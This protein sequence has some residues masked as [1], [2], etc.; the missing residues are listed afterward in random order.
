MF[1]FLLKIFFWFYPLISLLIIIG[2]YNFNYEK[3]KVINKAKRI[4]IND[5]IILGDS[6]IGQLNRNGFYNA[7]I[8]GENYSIILKKLK[9]FR[10]Y[11]NKKFDTLILG[12]SPR[13]LFSIE[14][15]KTNNENIRKY[16]LLD[17]YFNNKLN[18]IS[19]HS[20]IFNSSLTLGGGTG[21]SREQDV[22]FK[23]NNASQNIHFQRKDLVYFIDSNCFQ[24]INYCKK[25]SNFF[26]LLRTPTSNY[27]KASIPE[28][29]ESDYNDEI[30]KISQNTVYFD[31]SVEEWPDNFFMDQNHLNYDGALQFDKSINNRINKF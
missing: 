23:S 22:E 13:I 16:S 2:L 29:V 11:K 18:F 26:L 10:E 5:N 6:E 1:K 24:L 17:L 31:F 21:A 4:S 9:L 8:G 14:N 25:N 19:L 28:N 7:C 15:Y 30:I 12:I 27:Y 20:L 3:K